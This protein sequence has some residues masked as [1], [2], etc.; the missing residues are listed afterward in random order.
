MMPKYRKLRAQRVSENRNIIAHY[1]QLM[2]DWLINK[3]AD[4]AARD[5]YADA[6]DLSCNSIAC[7]RIAFA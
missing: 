1:D 7:I 4:T 5:D 2:M 3:S 6:D